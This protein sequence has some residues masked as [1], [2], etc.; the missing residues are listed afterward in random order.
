M[1]KFLIS[2][3]LAGALLLGSCA[4]V[5]VVAFITA[6]QQNVATACLI[7]PT[8]QTIADI[9]AAGNPALAT[10]EAVAAAICAAVKPK[11][12][13]GASVGGVPIRI[14]VIGRAP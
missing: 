7:V 14:I 2:T 12:T 1:L 8:A 6:V 13:E 9:I 3:S 5:D 10:V 11:G 4:S